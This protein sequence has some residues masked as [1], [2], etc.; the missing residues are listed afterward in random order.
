M[1]SSNPSPS[2]IRKKTKK[3]ALPKLFEHKTVYFF[4]IY[5]G[6]WRIGRCY[7]ENNLKCWVYDF[8]KKSYNVLKHQIQIYEKNLQPPAAQAN[9]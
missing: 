8:N 1:A 6:F 9:S 3:N 5:H 2:P 4:D 7:K